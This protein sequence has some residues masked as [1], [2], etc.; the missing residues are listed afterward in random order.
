MMITLPQRFKVLWMQSTKLIGS[1][2]QFYASGILT[3]ARRN[4]LSK[5]FWECLA[6]PPCPSPKG[7]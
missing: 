1:T 3:P 2:Q 7:V 6:T 5:Y 4:E